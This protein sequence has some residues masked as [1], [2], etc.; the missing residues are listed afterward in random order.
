[1]STMYPNQGTTI[2]HHLQPES[3]RSSGGVLSRAF[4]FNIYNGT[5]LR[6]DRLYTPCNLKQC[7]AAQKISNFRIS[8]E[9]FLKSSHVADRKTTKIMLHDHHPALGIAPLDPPQFEI[10][11]ACDTVLFNLAGVPAMSKMYPN[12]GTTTPHYLQPG[13]ARLSAGVLSRAFYFNIYN[14]T[15]LR[16]DRLYTPCNLKHCAAAQEFGQIFKKLGP[17]D[18]SLKPNPTNRPT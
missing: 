18:A 11:F 16:V 3:A 5:K 14:G 4:H 8:G 15:I 10:I 2:P 17:G 12:Q 9:N 1:M 13:S 7:A 6:V